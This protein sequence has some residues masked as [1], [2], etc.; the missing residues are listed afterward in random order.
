MKLWLQVLRDQT[1]W[2]LQ[3]AVD[4]DTVSELS[5][6]R[7][8]GSSGLPPTW[9]SSCFLAGA[10]GCLFQAQQLCG[11]CQPLLQPHPG[12]VGMPGMA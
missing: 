11:H 8:L 1:K 2:R 6:L 9:A 12:A 3:G 5:D 10:H 4:V 7:G